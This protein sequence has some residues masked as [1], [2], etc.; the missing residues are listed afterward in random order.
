MKE[1]YEEQQRLKLEAELEAYRS[2]TC[3]IS[4]ICCISSIFTCSFSFSQIQGKLCRIKKE[5][6]DKEKKKAK[7]NQMKPK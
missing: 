4:F 7:L 1:L 5:Q 2:F 6:D 3:C